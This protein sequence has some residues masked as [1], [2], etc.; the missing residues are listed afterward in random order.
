MKNREETDLDNMALSAE[1]ARQICH[2]FSNFLFNLTLQLEINKAGGA[3][4]A[5]DFWPAV[6]QDCR[7]IARALQE[8]DRFHNRFHQAETSID[9]REVVGQVACELSSPDRP[10]TLSA[11]PSAAAVS[12]TASALDCRHLLRLVLDDLFDSRQGVS[13]V[14]L[15]TTATQEHGL[16]RIVAAT[17]V[18]I[19]SETPEENAPTL[20]ARACR[21]L[22]IRLGVSIQ[23]DS[24][25]RAATIS[26]GFPLS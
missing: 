15:E 12:I 7:K 8:W 6:E 9:L 19:V 18:P 4:V 1:L 14:L 17:A 10:V 23:R 5:E 22:A 3:G 26:I 16:V 2:D 13:M 24:S 20:M 25:P 11:S 21:S